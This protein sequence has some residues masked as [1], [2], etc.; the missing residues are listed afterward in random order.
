MKL[1]EYRQYVVD[2]LN[3]EGIEVVGI[4]KLKL[5]P[6]FVQLVPGEPYVTLPETQ[7]MN[8]ETELGV[9]ISF[10][11]QIVAGRVEQDT[12][13]DIMDDLLNKCLFA[14]RNL[15]DI[16]VS[17]LIVQDQNKQ[18]MVVALVNFSITDNITQ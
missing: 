10:T 1:N 4:D 18:Q 6:P 14:V 9:K 15:D 2:E 16:Q 12:A 8:E 5:D 3:N 17:S 13:Y 11:L 7:T